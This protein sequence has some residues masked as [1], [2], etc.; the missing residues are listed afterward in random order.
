[1]PNV[2]RNAGIP[3]S[4]LNSYSTQNNRKSYPAGHFLLIDS[5]GNRKFPV[6]DPETGALHCG[7]I[8]HAIQRASQFGYAEVKTK[9][10][11]L[12][13]THCV[14]KD[15]DLSFKV[16]KEDLQGIVLGIV[17]SPDEPPDQDGHVLTKEAIEEMCWEYNKNFAILKYRHS[18]GLTKEEAVTLE[19]YIAPCNLMINGHEIKEGAWLMRVQL[20]DPK[21]KEQVK[22][23]VIK[24]LSLGGYIIDSEEIT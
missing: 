13:Q 14:S 11:N 24:G 10:E 15:K 7:L 20:I 22:D 18:M 4:I 2:T 19:S 6:K 17:A 1:M 9:A 23:G 16:M 21:L 12:Y 5:E 3:D 8:R